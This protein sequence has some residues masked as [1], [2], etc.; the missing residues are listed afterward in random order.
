MKTRTKLII[1]LLIITVNAYSQ[2][3]NILYEQKMIGLSIS[4]PDTWNI[5]SADEYYNNLKGIVLKDQEYA[6]M[7]QK[8]AT[9]PMFALTKY[10]E[11]F[12]DINPSI[13]MNTKPYGQLKG[14]SLI[15][16]SNAIIK[17]ISGMYNEFNIEVEPCEI[18]IANNKVVY[19]MISFQMSDVKG[20]NY[21]VVSEMYFIDKI[22]YFIMI[23]NSYDKD[24]KYGAKEEI[25]NML[26]TLVIK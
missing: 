9:I 20:N 4:Y 8:Y 10:K 13:K 25:K 3:K 12:N 15:N 1:T 22:N 17:Q 26:S 23:G 18:N 11:P 6:E 14:I 21:D 7:I 24:N 19:F 2:G 5:V 16:M